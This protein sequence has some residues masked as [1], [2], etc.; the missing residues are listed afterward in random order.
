MPAFVASRRPRSKMGG[1]RKVGSMRQQLK[2]KTARQLEAEER[3]LKR[4]DSDSEESG[5]EIPSLPKPQVTAIVE[6]PVEDS[7]E[8]EAPEESE[9]EEV[10]SSEVVENEEDEDSDA[11]V[12]EEVTESEEDE[13][14]GEEAA[15]DVVENDDDDEEVDSDEEVKAGDESKVKEKSENKEAVSGWADS[16]AKIL[17]SSKPKNKKEMM[18]SRARKD[19]EV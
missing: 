6:D 16:I 19:Y 2:P 5:S 14:S 15:S 10:E 17:G 1:A 11:E 7:E 12:G 4:F 13:D 9:K 18:L 3:R 8:E